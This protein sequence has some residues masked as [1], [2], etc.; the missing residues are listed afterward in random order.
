MANPIIW[1]FKD[2]GRKVLTGIYEYAVPAYGKYRNLLYVIR[3]KNK[4]YG[5]FATI[6]LVDVFSKLPL[7]TKIKIIYLGLKKTK[8][9]NMK[10]TYKITHNRK[11]I[12]TRHAK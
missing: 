4:R 11:E 12:K 1:N 2:K 6:E 8:R 10:S 7:K 3:Q 5:I 9:G